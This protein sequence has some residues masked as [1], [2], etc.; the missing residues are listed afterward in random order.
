MAKDRLGLEPI[1]VSRSV[2]SAAIAHERHNQ[3]MTPPFETMTPT[4]QALHYILSRGNITMISQGT[5]YGEWAFD[6]ALRPSIWGQFDNIRINDTKHWQAGKITW[7]TDFRASLPEDEDF[8]MA[9]DSD[10]PDE[11]GELLGVYDVMDPDDADDQDIFGSV[12]VQPPSL[13]SPKGAHLV[14]PSFLS[15]LTVKR[16]NFGRMNATCYIAAPLQIVHNIP[17]L[18]DIFKQTMV[19][20]ANTGRHRMVLSSRRDIFFQKHAKAFTKTAETFN[21]LDQW[22][23]LQKLLPGNMNDLRITYHDL[24]KL[25]KDENEDAGHFFDWFMDIVNTVMD[26]SPSLRNIADKLRPQAIL[27]SNATSTDHWGAWLQSG[28]DSEVSHVLGVQSVQHVECHRCY[29]DMRVFNHAHSISLHMP[30]NFGRDDVPLIQLLTGWAEGDAEKECSKDSA[31]GKHAATS[32]YF[33]VLPE[34]LVMRI[35][36]SRR[37]QG[38]SASATAS[39]LQL[40]RTLDILEDQPI[41]NKV[42]VTETLDLKDFIS[43]EMSDGNTRYQLVGVLMFISK[44][45]HFV[46]FVR[47]SK[48]GKNFEGDWVEFDDM[49]ARPMLRSPFETGSQVYPTLSSLQDLN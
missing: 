12:V 11:A 40:Q 1:P 7:K 15:D 37:S 5:N 6:E 4:N 34:I 44:I 29:E 27:T 22:P 9:A 35:M 32:R 18:R 8:E 26:T 19:L 43:S 16:R 49:L 46:T 30:Q 24:N 2:A 39:S 23:A 25:W 48:D 31:H 38:A 14:I 20:N 10:L 17:A 42:E 36:R 47:M 28:N 21:M 45:K 13:Q 3:E 41:V 33:T